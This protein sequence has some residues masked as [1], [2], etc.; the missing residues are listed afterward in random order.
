[1]CNV[2]LLG[3]VAS[4]YHTAVSKFSAELKLRIDANSYL[5]EQVYNEEETEVCFGSEYLIDLF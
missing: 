2:K 5:L 4:A 3:D 1:M